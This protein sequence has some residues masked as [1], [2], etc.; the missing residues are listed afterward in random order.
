MEFTI[1]S[2]K[3]LFDYNA[4]NDEELTFKKGDLLQI[5]ERTPDGNWWDG[6]IGRKRGY[7]PVAYVE[8]IELPPDHNSKAGA[9]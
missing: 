7:I 6:F 8:I 2:A 4:R 1:I 5:I 9:L 3:A